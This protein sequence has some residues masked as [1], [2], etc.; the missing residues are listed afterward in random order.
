MPITWE[1]QAPPAKTKNE[2]AES[3]TPRFNVSKF[4]GGEDNQLGVDRAIIVTL[5]SGFARNPID[6]K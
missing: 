3:E 4:L 1:R 2:A 6:K 5:R